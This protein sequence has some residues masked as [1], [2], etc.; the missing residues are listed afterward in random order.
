MI[1]TDKAA[2][3]AGTTR[4]TINNWI[5]SG[6]CIGLQGMTRGW[7]LPD[8]QFEPLVWPA[9][10]CLSTKLGTKDG[11][12]LLFFLESP[13]DALDGETPVKALEQGVKVDRILQL[14][15]AEAH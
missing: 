2:E 15:Q 12:T 9:V 1:T 11:W 8:W 3:L 13:I 5:K 7:K 6:R 14:A 4:V 10:Q